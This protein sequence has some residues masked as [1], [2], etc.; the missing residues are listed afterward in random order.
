[1]Y[2]SSSLFSKVQS[3]STVPD[4]FRFL[5]VSIAN[6]NKFLNFNNDDK[7]PLKAPQTD[8]QYSVC[9]CVLQT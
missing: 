1:M 3:F 9:V 7:E 4:Q 2:T 6:L 8:S 5:L